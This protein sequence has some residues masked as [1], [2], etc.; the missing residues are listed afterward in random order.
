MQ[1]IVQLSTAYEGLAPEAKPIPELREVVPQEVPILQEQRR[2]EREMDLQRF[3]R[4]RRLQAEAIPS[5][6]PS[7]SMLWRENMGRSPPR[8]RR[9]SVVD[10]VGF[11]VA[12]VLFCLCSSAHLCLP[13]RYEQCDSSNFCCKSESAF[14]TLC[15]HPQA[16]A[17]RGPLAES[18]PEV[19]P[20]QDIPMLAQGQPMLPL[21]KQAAAPSPKQAT[22]P[23]PKPSPRA[24]PEGT[25][26]CTVESCL[27][28]K[29]FRAHLRKRAGCGAHTGGRASSVVWPAHGSRP[30]QG[31]APALMQA[32]VS[33]LT[34]APA[35]APTQA[36]S[37]F[38]GVPR[39][40]IPMQAQGQPMPATPF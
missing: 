19:M 9:I 40:E 8:L 15:T 10:S 6:L 38:F 23:L 2:A 31:P 16:A 37:K 18:V 35:P 26:A 33:V 1:R 39:Q 7:I 4:R 28:F 5:V 12:D 17:L 21:P 25:D 13:M 14:G 24:F 27:K 30:D 3:L 22:A 32:P 20:T 29:E 34:Q 36:P 11:S